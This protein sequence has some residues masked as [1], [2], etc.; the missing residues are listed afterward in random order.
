MNTMSSGLE[1][2]IYC[3]LHAWYN[4]L[5]DLDTP[6]F[7]KLPVATDCFYHEEMKKPLK[8]NHG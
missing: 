4:K 3:L 1:A 8:K 6:D 7:G 2:D 5:K